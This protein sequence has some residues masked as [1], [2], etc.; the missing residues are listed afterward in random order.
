[1]LP[2][3][4]SKNIDLQVEYEGNFPD[5]FLGDEYRIKTILINLI[6]NAIKFTKDGKVHVS[7][8]CSKVDRKGDDEISRRCIVEIAVV[9]TGIGIS[10]KDQASIFIPFNK[11]SPSW[12][13]LYKGVGMGLTKVSKF[14]ED[15]GGEMDLE[16][17]EGKGFTFTVRL[18][19]KVS[20]LAEKSEGLLE[21]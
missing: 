13:G 2:T 7:L 4:E 18:P 17:S 3:C 1:M 6:G 12:K 5:F 19:L 10:S 20:L 16:S 21:H 15:I 14:L 8:K 9:D 11:L